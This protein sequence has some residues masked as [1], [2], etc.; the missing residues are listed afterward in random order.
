MKGLMTKWERFLDCMLASFV[1]ALAL[2]AL[3]LVFESAGLPSSLALAS[4]DSESGTLAWRSDPGR[5]ACL[6]LDVLCH[7]AL[8]DIL[9]VYWRPK[10][11]PSLAQRTCGA[12]T[13]DDGEFAT[14]QFWSI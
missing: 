3:A 10:K 4:S 5:Q 7:G 13:G 1:T 2:E 14:L 6:H 11:R 12:G 9:A 8:L